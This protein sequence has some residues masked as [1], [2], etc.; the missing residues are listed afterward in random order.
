MVDLTPTSK[1]AAS[2]ADGVIT[3]QAPK[4]SVSPG[5]IAQP[6]NELSDALNKSADVLMNDIAVP[7]A[8]KQAADDLIKQKVTRND[9]GSVTVTN[10]ASAPLLF[11][12]AAT[13]Y[14]DAVTSGTIAQN[15]NELS[16]KFTELHQKFPT[17]PQGFKAAS[18]AYLDA[19][20]GQVAGPMGEAIQREGAQLQTQHFN[21][22]TNTTATNDIENQKKSIQAQSED[23]KNTL[24]GLARQGGTGTPEYQQALAK[25]NN[26]QDALVSN[27]LFKTPQEQADRDKKNTAALMDSEALV[28]HID[29]TFNRKN[30]KAE[31]QKQLNDHVLNN[32]DMKEVDRQRLYTL[33]MS[34]L[35]YLSGDAKEAIDANR[36]TIDLLETNMANGKVKPDNP[37]VGMALQHANSLGDTEGVKRI[38]GAAQNAPHMKA[39]D[40]LPDA[41][42]AEVLGI[43]GPSGNGP[44]NQ[45]IPPEGRALLKTIG[46]TESANR[47]NVRYS[48]GGDKTFNSFS[49]HPRVAEPITSGPDVGKTSSAA[50]YYQFIGSTWDQQKQKLGL[51]DFSPAN[52]DTAAWDLAQT[53][54][55][56]KTGKDLLTTLQSGQTADVLPSLSSQWS[57]LPGGRQPANRFAAP[58]ANG[59]PGFTSEQVQRNPFLMSAYIR[60][61][62]A[63]PAGRVDA[64]RQVVS[65]INTGMDKGILPSPDSVAQVYQAAELHPEHLGNAAT[66]LRGRLI[67]AAGSSLPQEQQA[68]YFKQMKDRAQ[69]QDIHQT[70]IAASA[71]KQWDEQKKN[72][73]EHPYDEAARRGWTQS[74][75]PIDPAQ[76]DGI[77]PALVQRATLS[78]RIGQLNHT[79]PPPLLDKDDMPKLQTALQSPQA[80][81]VLS[82]IAQALR[83]DE[84]HT[85]LGEDGFRSSVTGMSRSGDPAKM[86][87]AYSFMDTQQKQNPLEFEK[88]FPDGL[89]DLRA[90]QTNLA[91]Y[92]PDEAAKRLLRSYDPAQGS[93]IKASNE[94]AHKALEAVSADAVVSKFSTGWGPIGTGA[95]APVSDMAGV[96]KG[97]L[98]ADYDQNYRDGFAATGDATMADNFAMEK[99]RLKY[100]VSPTNGN[101]VMA[102]APEKYYPQV[103]GSHDWMTQQLDEAVAKHLGVSASGGAYDKNLPPGALYGEV[104]PG[105]TFGDETPSER[106]YNAR[107]ALVSDQTTDRDIASGKPPSYQVIVQDVNGRW[108]VLTGAAVEGP[109]MVQR[110]R[111]DPSAPFAKRSQDMEV[112]RKQT[113]SGMSDSDIASAAVQ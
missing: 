27:P 78:T 104:K 11:G 74:A 9:D 22:I 17:D 12:N 61:L 93:A 90:W 47:Y 92:P 25:Y 80:P 15:G 95:R 112:R 36:K 33:G 89:K 32:L 75:A 30:G 67:G 18:D 63:D 110:F 19:R 81:A 37:I 97:A 83:P 59:G 45:S 13:A 29:A 50:G 24:I 106:R 111:F 70:N 72:M 31:A 20:A 55:K 102:N 73:Q 87:A 65:A 5:Q 79:P 23:Q 69:G 94:T 51:T 103:G 113:M 58:S 96:A 7:L 3:S 21:S 105:D 98:K 68:A 107:R 82:S 39:L 28:A 41:I 38:L 56:Q 91:F 53:T 40:P 60:T 10:P 48:G 100:A 108:S 54:Y 34:R 99:L 8:K 57:S 6:Y 109:N 14:K 84:M 43:P 85:L 46:S 88:Q 52:Q 49:D 64:A 16:Q 86:N 4:S 26:S 2:E 66:D 101:K 62:A 71:L 1:Q 76:P 35:A 77:A 44:V 42:K